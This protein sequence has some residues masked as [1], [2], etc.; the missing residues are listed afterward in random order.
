MITRS[1]VNAR[2]GSTGIP[3][4]GTK[5]HGIEGGSMALPLVDTITVNGT[6]PPFVT[7]TVAGTWHTAPSGAPLQASDTVPL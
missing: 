4:K 7:V 6:W 3:T 1:R 2:S 5:R